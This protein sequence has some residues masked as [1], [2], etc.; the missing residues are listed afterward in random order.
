MQQRKLRQNLEVSALGLGCMGM[1]LFYGQPPRPGKI[2]IKTPTAEP[3]PRPVDASSRTT[4]EKG[5]KW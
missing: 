3:N 4:N 5:G 1:S 2:V